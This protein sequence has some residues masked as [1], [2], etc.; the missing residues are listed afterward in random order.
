[1]KRRGPARCV[2]LAEASVVTRSPLAS[3]LLDLR[4]MS[5]LQALAGG[6]ILGVAAAF[7]MLTHGRIAG[8][9][10]IAS[11]TLTERGG[12]LRWRLAFLAGLAVAG[13]GAALVA[14]AAIG[15]APRSIVTVAIAGGLVGFGSRLGSGCT[16]GHGV[17]GLSRGSRRAFV[18]VGTFMLTAALTATLA[19][20]LS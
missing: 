10:G 5:V 9:S 14:P 2:S 20:R 15:A 4:G 17:C 19:G 1:M 13:I 11:A 7:L 16:S 6:A 12:E 18:A 3:R 8:I